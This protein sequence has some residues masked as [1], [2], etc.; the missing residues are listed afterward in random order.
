MMFYYL[1]GGKTFEIGGFS[2]AFFEIK[3]VF[4]MGIDS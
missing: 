3:G 4:E 2:F 1:L